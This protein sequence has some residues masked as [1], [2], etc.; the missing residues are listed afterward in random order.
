MKA[1]PLRLEWL[2]YPAASFQAL[3]REQPACGGVATKVSASVAYSL[4]GVHSVELKL[5]SRDDDAASAAYSFAVEAVA[6]F[7]FD[8]EVAR[9]AYSNSSAESLPRVIAVNMA[10]IVYSSARE[11]LATFTARAPYG[12][13]LIDSVLIGPEDIRVGSNEP[14]EQVLEKIF[15][16]EPPKPESSKPEKQPGQRKPK[17]LAAG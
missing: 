2:A 9:A 12:S 8:L 3:Y 17:R 11:L 10:R 4:D 1:S 14:E 7:T 6:G 5:S 16:L 15:G 13:V